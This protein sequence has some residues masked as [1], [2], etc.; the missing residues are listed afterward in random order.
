MLDIDG[1]PCSIGGL[2]RVG[3]LTKKI[4][5]ILVQYTCTLHEWYVMGVYIHNNMHLVAVKITGWGT[6]WFFKTILV[7][8]IWLM[9]FLSIIY[10]APY[11]KSANCSFGSL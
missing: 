2:C 11:L 10:V 1:N 7:D 9:G 3:F 8:Y 5:N 6:I 4:D